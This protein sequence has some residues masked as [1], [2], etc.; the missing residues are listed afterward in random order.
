[1]IISSSNRP[2]VIYLR[3]TDFWKPTPQCTSKS[4]CCLPRVLWAAGCIQQLKLF[5][6]QHLAIPGSPQSDH[7]VSKL[8]T[9]AGSLWN[10]VKQAWSHPQNSA[11]HLLGLQGPQQTPAQRMLIHPECHWYFSIYGQIFVDV[12]VIPVLNYPRNLTGIPRRQKAGLSI[13]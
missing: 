11:S 5:F 13:K 6:F 1:M 9:D 12:S 8:S 10:T 2:T 7:T 4:H 3:L